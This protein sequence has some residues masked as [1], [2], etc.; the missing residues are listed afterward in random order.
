VS[1]TTTIKSHPGKKTRS[2]RARFAFSADQPGASFKCK[3]DRGAL[4][5]CSSPVV[6]RNLRPGA[7][8]L[9]IVAIGAAGQ[10]PA[11]K[12]SWKV[13]PKPKKKR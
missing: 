12:F 11:A 3:L 2:G 6:Y 1:P 7:H 13:L 10:G 8:T 4:A 5:A 9:T